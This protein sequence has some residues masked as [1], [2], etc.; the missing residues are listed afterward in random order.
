MG[1]PAAATAAN[2]EKW[3]NEAAEKIAEI[4]VAMYHFVPRHDA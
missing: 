3:V 4:L 1:D 2:G